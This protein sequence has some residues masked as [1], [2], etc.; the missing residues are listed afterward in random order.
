[1]CGRW[2][3]W[4][5]YSRPAWVFC[6]R[7]LGRIYINIYI[8]R[9][10]VCVCVLAGPRVHRR[11]QAPPAGR[12]V[13]PSAAEYL[14]YPEYPFVSPV[15]AGVLARYFDMCDEFMQAVFARWP[16]V[17]VQAH[18]HPIIAIILPRG[19]IITRCYCNGCILLSFPY[20]G[21]VIIP[22]CNDYNWSAR[23]SRTSRR[24]RPSRCSRGEAVPRQ[25]YRSSTPAVVPRQDPSSTPRVRH[26][27]PNARV[28]P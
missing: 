23:S 12:G 14:E 26:E 25:Q 10:C 5:E 6:V 28:R 16:D 15:P 7:A 22:R 9:V 3:R 11:V 18:P 4:R 2:L 27:P 13:R 8:T 24:P 20:M 17:V 1:M 21:R 19:A